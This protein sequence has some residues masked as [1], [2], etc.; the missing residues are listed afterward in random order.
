[1]QISY[2]IIDK[3]YLKYNHKIEKIIKEFENESYFTIKK[4]RNTI[5]ITEIGNTKIVIKSFKVPNLLN[6]IIYTFFR[7]SKALRSF[8]YAK[9]LLKRGINTPIPIAVF[10]T[11]KNF[12]IDRTFYVCEHID[13]DFT[14]KEFISSKYNFKKVLEEF[15]KFCY[16]LHQNNINFLDNTPGNTLIKHNNH[17]FDF[18]LVDLNRMKFEKMSFK[19]RMKNLSMLT[20]DNDIILEISKIYSKMIHVEPNIIYKEINFFKTKFQNKLKRKDK[21]KRI[22]RLK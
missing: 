1:M 12:F 19:K 6:K 5:K 9:K 13:Y 2:N 3:D 17:S 7:K 18:F 16:K 4:G 8:Q 20:V 15:S 21:L 10:E 11:K 22:L 14:F